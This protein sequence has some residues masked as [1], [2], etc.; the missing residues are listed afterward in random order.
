MVNSELIQLL[1]NSIRD[2]GKENY[3]SST[4]ASALQIAKY[5]LIGLVGKDNIPNLISFDMPIVRLTGS[6]IYGYITVPSNFDEV[7][8]MQYLGGD[9]P[10]PIEIVSIE[11]LSRYQYKY[12]GGDFY[13]PKASRESSGNA[14]LILGIKSGT[15]LIHY[16]RKPAVVADNN[17]S[18]DIPDYYLPNLIEIAQSV[19]LSWEEKYE[20]SELKMRRQ[21]EELKISK[22]EKEE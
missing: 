2:P 9:R 12:S 21:I 1:A 3:S 15:V 13:E 6:G 17:E 14:F 20:A 10:V 22:Q 7:L 11:K 18:V 8:S 19:L 5:K 16:R 4:L